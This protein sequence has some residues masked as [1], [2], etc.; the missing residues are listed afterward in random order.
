MSA[1]AT[2]MVAMGIAAIAG[3]DA[4]R[5]GFGLF[6]CKADDVRLSDLEPLFVCQGRGQPARRPS[7]VARLSQRQFAE[8][9]S[10]CKKSHKGRIFMNRTV[11]LISIAA[12][13]GD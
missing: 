10:A 8:I 11:A 6:F 2:D 9:A 4:K 3:I 13:F 1:A 5:E 12:A 7:V